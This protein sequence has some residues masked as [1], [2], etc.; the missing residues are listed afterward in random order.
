[1]LIVIDDP[2]RENQGDVIFPA[3]TATVAKV[4]FLM[5]ECRGMFCVPISIEI[6][7]RLNITPM[8][9]EKKN[10]EKFS[11]NFGI[12]VDAKDVT[13]FGIS[14]ADRK[15]TIDTLADKHATKTDL[16]FP[17]HVSPLIAAK[18]GIME[19]NGHTEATIE[20]AKLAGFEPI[21]VLSEVIRDDGEVAL[22]DDLISFS[23]KHQL[24]IVTI[25]DLKVYLTNR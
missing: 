10:T 11:C 1:M 25:K 18:G 21:G 6:A 4:N 13:S 19:R 23:K 12:T 7:L 14:A 24:K 8:V 9:P 20:L 5:K 2:D 17:G 3:A 22:F 15:L 16:L